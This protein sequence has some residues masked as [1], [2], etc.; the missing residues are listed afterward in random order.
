M[1]IKN[2]ISFDFEQAK[3]KHL[4][5]KSRLRS[6][7][8]GIDVNDDKPVLSQ[9]ECEVGK[10][11]YSKGMASYGNLKE[12]QELE[13][14]HGEIHTTAKKLVNQYR[15]GEV[16]LA[17]SG[18]KN[19]EDIADKLV[20]LLDA[21]KHKVIPL[22][23]KNQQE[24]ED[25][26]LHELIRNNE[27]LDS[28][29]KDQVQETQRLNDRFKFVSKA[30]HDAIWDWD[31]INNTVWWGEGFYNLFGYTNEE[32]HRNPEFWAEKIHPDDKTHV[33]QSRMQSLN[34]I[35]ERWSKEYRFLKADKTY[36]HVIDRGFA[37][38]DELTHKTFRMVGSM[39]DISH[40]K[41]AEMQ[42]K[43]VFEML[44]HL[45]WTMDASGNII[46]MWYSKIGVKSLE[47]FNIQEYIFPE[48]YEPMERSWQ[49]AL[50]AR[51]PYEGEYRLKDTTGAYRWMQLK[52]NPILDSNKNANSWVGTAIDV[53]DK[54]TTNDYLENKVNE[55]TS[56]LKRINTQLERSNYD[57]MQFASVA[58][59][60]LKE[61][62]R[63]V[64]VYGNM[65]EKKLAKLHDPE[66]LGYIGRMTEA[67]ERMKILIDDILAYSKLSKDS[68]P[69]QKI[70]LNEIIDQIIIDFEVSVKEKNAGFS[71]GD[72]GSIVGDPIQI[73]QLF[74]NL[75]SNSLKFSH[76]DK[77][78][79][80]SIESMATNGLEA[81]QEAAQHYKKIVFK[82]NGIGFEMKF[83]EKI[84]TI[85]QRL[86]TRQSY[87][88]T[89]IGLS[90][91][92]KVV[93]NHKGIIRV[94]SKLGEGSTFILYLPE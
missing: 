77:D 61:P 38:Q 49:E 34:T 6:I 78:L 31:L 3:I 51:I 55:R 93:D 22:A 74:Q 69:F 67:A 87:D 59:H 21:V 44:P 56:E 35:G 15:S 57:L 11:I 73:R 65:L 62:L 60:D 24:V 26:K 75:I 13:H 37:L 4:L 54:K 8:Y 30:T 19:M 76:L 39:V 29:I 63:K 52:I 58:S 70:N 12:M 2:S 9:Y 92:K 23:D 40:R 20:G 82:D 50:A 25:D 80:I 17:R 88:G 71:I 85:F 79:Q 33:L 72:L 42:L 47:K 16:D 81:E 66:S 48:D 83:S 10:W 64:Q 32:V 18:L 89:G 27:E 90:I 28:K 45:A 5:F 94:E 14:V 46:Y 86:H 68:I 36:A 41:E 43:Q 84:F 91:V 7:L 1:E 53:H